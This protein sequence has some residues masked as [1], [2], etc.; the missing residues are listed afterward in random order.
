LLENDGHEIPQ[1]CNI[2]IYRYQYITVGLFFWLV[3]RARHS[4]LIL[5]WRLSWIH[6]EEI[7][8][9]HTHTHTHMCP[10][11]WTVFRS[12]HRAMT[13]RGCKSHRWSSGK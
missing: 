13:L 5:G 1:Y 3:D 11:Y 10:W 7:V 8:H 2:A 6:P 9:T 12:S 4:L